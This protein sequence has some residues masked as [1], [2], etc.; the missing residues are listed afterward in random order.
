MKPKNRNLLEY[1][2]YVN[3]ITHPKK[4]MP[5]ILQMNKK[6]SFIVLEAMELLEM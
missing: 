4:L 2:I 5:K 1:L 6:L 3:L